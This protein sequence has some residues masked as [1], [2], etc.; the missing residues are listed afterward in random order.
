MSSSGAIEISASRSLEVGVCPVT[1]EG[2]HFAVF[3]ERAGGCDQTI[4][5][6]AE[7]GSFADLERELFES[8][9]LEPGSDGR[10]EVRRTTVPGPDDGG[11][12]CAQRRQQPDR[13][14]NVGISDVPEHAADQDD[15]GRHRAQVGRCRRRVPFDDLQVT[16]PGRIASGSSLSDELRVTFHKT[17]EDVAAARVIGEHSDDVAALAGAHAENANGTFPRVVERATE[18]RLHYCQAPAQRGIWILVCRVP[19]DPVSIGNH[20]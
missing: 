20:D 13:P 10:S 2:E 11:P 19:P 6:D 5:P 9:L 16:K 14:T 7:A 15:V 3:D 17:C 12:G 8:L 4:R 18:A 1:H